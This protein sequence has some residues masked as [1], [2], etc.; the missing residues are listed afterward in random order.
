MKFRI[1][2]SVCL[3]ISSA[4][5]LAKPAYL[6]EFDNQ[7]NLEDELPVKSMLIS[8]Q[9]IANKSGPQLYFVYPPQWPWKITSAMRGF[10][11][12]RHNFDFKVLGSAE[13]ALDALGHRAKG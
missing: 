8:L 12:D 2:V 1:L 4:Q 9:G 7:W 11:E 13:E 5:L 6:M 10:F 3:I